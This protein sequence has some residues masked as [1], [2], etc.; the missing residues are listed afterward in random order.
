MSNSK[1]TAGA[2]AKEAMRR[3]SG[4]FQGWR[5]HVLFDELFCLHWIP[6]GALLWTP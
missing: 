5:S 2:A 4:R 3:N 6:D 1:L